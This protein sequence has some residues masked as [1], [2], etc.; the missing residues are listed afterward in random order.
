MDLDSQK[1]MSEEDRKRTTRKLSRG[2]A[3]FYVVNFVGL[4]L[5]IVAMEKLGN[6]KGLIVMLASIYGLNI[7]TG[8][9]ILRF[10]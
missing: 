2:L 6:M 7:L 8:L 3:L 10:T 4:I 9:G 5:G 1:D